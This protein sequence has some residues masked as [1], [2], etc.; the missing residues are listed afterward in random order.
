MKWK[1]LV[2]GMVLIATGCASN[3]GPYAAMAEFGYDYDFSL[4][5]T[6]GRTPME[7]GRD[8]AAAIGP[9]VTGAQIT[10]QPAPYFI[11]TSTYP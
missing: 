7:M 9:P 1:L 6:P 4:P 11:G 3:N 5:P 2:C 10:M 8:Y